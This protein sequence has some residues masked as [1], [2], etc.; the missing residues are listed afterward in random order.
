MYETPEELEA[1]DSLLA[2]SRRTATN[3]LRDIIDDD[4]ALSADDLTRLLTGMKVLAIA[5]VT[6]AGEPR[7]SCVDGHFLHGTWSFSTA[8]DAAKARHLEQRPQVSVAHVDGEALAV[9]SHGHAVPMAEDHPHRRQTLDHWT[10]H[11]GSD[12]LT[13]GPDIRLYDYRPD[14][15]VGFALDRA[16]LLRQSA[17]GG[18]L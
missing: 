6:A 9:F 2:R 13:W 8:G 15:M 7:I 17:R 16:G 18:T 10:A 3:H 11:Y 12:P 4:R 1:L 5:T 14:W